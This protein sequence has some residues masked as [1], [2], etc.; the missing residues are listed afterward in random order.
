MKTTTENSVNKVGVFIRNSEARFGL[1]MAFPRDLQIEKI[2]DL[3]NQLSEK[4]FYH[5][6]KIWRKHFKKETLPNGDYEVNISKNNDDFLKP[7]DF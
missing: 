1:T 3:A 7:L 6:E 4:T 2:L 5:A